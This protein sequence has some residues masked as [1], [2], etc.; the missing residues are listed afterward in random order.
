MPAALSRLPVGSSASTIAGR[1][2][3]ARA[4]ATR[5]RSP[6]ESFGGRNAAAARARRGRAPRP[7]ARAAR[8]RRR[9]RRAGRR[10][11]SRAPRSAR[12]GGTAGRRSRCG[13]PAA[14]RGPDPT[15]SRRPARDRDA[16]L[17]RAVERADQMQQRRL[18][19]PRR[20]D[21]R[22]Q[23]AGQHRERHAAQ[24]LH[25]RLA[26]IGLRGPLELEHRRGHEVAGTTTRCPALSAPVT[27]T[28]PPAVSN[29]PSRTGTSR[30]FPAAPATSTA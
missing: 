19:R 3:S 13:R 9:R 6:P 24:G 23:L 16:A 7:R 17:G 22:D 14:P 12:R 29:R 15:A 8:A 20:A 10:R 28:R 5:W 18:A 11:R 4:I 21:H 25:R 27:C 26:R 30:R 1:P 2:T